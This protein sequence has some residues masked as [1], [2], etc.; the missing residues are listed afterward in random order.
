MFR[1]YNAQ[2]TFFWNYFINP[3]LNNKL[4][5]IFSVFYACMFYQFC[6]DEIHPWGVV[7]GGSTISQ[8]SWLSIIPMSSD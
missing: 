4:M 7:G 6:L 1:A 8:S 5:S 2:V 3:D